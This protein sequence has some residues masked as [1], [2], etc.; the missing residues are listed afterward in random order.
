MSIN[1]KEYIVW[2]LAY[3]SFIVDLLTCGVQWYK[4][5]P[6]YVTI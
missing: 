1:Y 5:Y 6:R 3:N 2:I 4:K